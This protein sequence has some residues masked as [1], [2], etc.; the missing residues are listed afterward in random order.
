MEGFDGR[1]IIAT[2]FGGPGTGK[3][4]GPKSWFGDYPSGN[5][6]RVF[7]SDDRG[8]T[9]RATSARTPMM[10]EILFKAGNALY[11][12]GHSKVLMITRSD[13]NGETW[14]EPSVLCDEGRWHQSCGA[15]DIH[16]GKITLV[17]EKWI[18]EGHPW[19]GV[20]KF[21]ELYNPDPDLVAAAESGIP[22]FKVDFEP[23][24]RKYE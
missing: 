20:G 24:K 1:F 2:D 16:N 8:I 22:S 17:Y 13:D 19:P 11:M 9:W 23:G 18:H 5:Q 21:S 12:I 7:L 15:V 6:I 3:L 10:H 4:D 14:S